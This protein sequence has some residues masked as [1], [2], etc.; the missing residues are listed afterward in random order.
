[1]ERVTVT[2][3]QRDL[4]ALVDR[5]YHLGISVDLEREK[6]VVARI[7]PVQSAKTLKVGEFSAFLKHL[8]QLGDD[9][10]SFDTDLRQIRRDFPLEG[11]AWD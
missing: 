1:M 8:P 11:A 5:V 9:A 3:A 4:A 2:D 10:E 6:Q 7:A